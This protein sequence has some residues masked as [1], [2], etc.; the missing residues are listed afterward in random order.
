M[1]KQN[2]FFLC[3]IGIIL[4]CIFL[5]CSET[6]SVEDYR[7]L[8]NESFKLLPEPDQQE[9]IKDLHNAAKQGDDEVIRKTLARG[10]PID[11]HPNLW[12]TPLMEASAKGNLS[13]VQLLV[14]R[15]AN[16]NF[17]HD[18]AG[19]TPLMLAIINKQVKVVKFLVQSEANVNIKASDGETALDKANLPYNQEIVDL[20]KKSRWNK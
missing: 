1:N 20:L 16:V 9:L 3:L 5:G 10:T 6:S 2:K 12:W 7:N 19:F 8:A 18:D 13:T 17:R 15:G 11:S 4:I 14:E